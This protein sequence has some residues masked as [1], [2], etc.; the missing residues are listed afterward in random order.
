MVTVNSD[1][2]TQPRDKTDRIFKLGLSSNP[3][4]NIS[5]SVRG[6][7]WALEALDSLSSSSIIPSECQ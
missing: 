2:G 7:C 3:L 1:S 6:Q 5:I 4:A